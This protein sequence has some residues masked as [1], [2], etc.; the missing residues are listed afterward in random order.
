MITIKIRGLEIMFSFLIYLI[1]V[2]NFYIDSFMARIIIFDT[3]YLSN[4][5][6]YN[7]FNNMKKGD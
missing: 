1:I 6:I 7:M 4:L 5:F 3:I 2:F